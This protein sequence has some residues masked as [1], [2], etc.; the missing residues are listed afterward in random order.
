[1][2]RTGAIA[3]A[4]NKATVSTRLFKIR[5]SE[6]Y[7]YKAW[8][9]VLIDSAPV[10]PVII[11]RGPIE[12]VIWKTPLTM[13]T[14]IPKV[15]QPRLYARNSVAGISNNIIT[16]KN[17]TARAPTYTSKFTRAKNSK[18]S[19]IRIKEEL[20]N[21]ITEYIKDI[22]G[23]LVYPTAILNKA[24]NKMAQF[25]K[26]IKYKIMGRSRLGLFALNDE[27]FN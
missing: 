19:N 14:K 12:G 25:S 15:L 11:P 1:V 7:K 5:I 4:P 27:R 2:E 24:H 16:N 22:N 20:I 8:P 18:P 9:R 10:K 23:D 3:K 13:K 26:N 17:N 6:K 21:S